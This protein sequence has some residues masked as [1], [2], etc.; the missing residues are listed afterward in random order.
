VTWLWRYTPNHRIRRAV[1]KNL[2]FGGD[3][4]IVLIVTVYIFRTF[5]HCR[6][7][8]GPCINLD[9]LVWNFNADWRS[10]CQFGQLELEFHHSCRS[11]RDH[12]LRRRGFAATLLS[13]G[14][15]IEDVLTSRGWGGCHIVTP[16]SRC[17]PH[18][19]IGIPH[20]KV[21]ISSFPY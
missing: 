6:E 10:M 20:A 12:V 16:G 8:G 19:G 4:P 1:G 11:R 5:G 17:A 3:A 21:G 7:V 13:A 14:A 2:R 9:G 18:T 15:L